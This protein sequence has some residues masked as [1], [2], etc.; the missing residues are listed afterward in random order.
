MDERVRPG[1]KTGSMPAKVLRDF[2]IGLAIILLI[3]AGV[4]WRKGRPAAPWEFGFAALSAGIALGFPQAFW[5]IYK[6]WMPMARFL[7][8]VNTFVALT[9]LYYLVITPYAIIARWIG[10]DLL[11]EKLKDRDSYWQPKTPANDLSG[12]THQ[13]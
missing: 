6:I 1:L 4:A 5:P 10:G 7:G 9:L 13:F 3:L 2:G 8:M 11:D 12:Y